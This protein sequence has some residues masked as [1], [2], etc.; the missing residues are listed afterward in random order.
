MWRQGLDR[1]CFPTI[2][3]QISWN[4][5]CSLSFPMLLCARAL[6]IAW[7]LVTHQKWLFTNIFLSSWGS[8]SR[9]WSF[10][11]WSHLSAVGATKCI[12]WNFV[13]YQAL[14]IRYVYSYLEFIYQ[15]MR[16]IFQE[17]VLAHSKDNEVK[18]WSFLPPPLSLHT[19]NTLSDTHS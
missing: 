1:Y 10:V 12:E 6:S 3:N 2:E 7:L 15:R 13:Y 19:H 14:W 9:V 16:R 17:C 4:L 11:P 5:K 18:H 8:V